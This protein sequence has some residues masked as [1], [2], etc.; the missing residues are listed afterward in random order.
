MGLIRR[1]FGQLYDLFQDFSWL[2][3]GYLLCQP[4]GAGVHGV[5]SGSCCKLKLFFF[6]KV[7]H[8]SDPHVGAFIRL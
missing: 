5:E 7:V 3:S 4:G 8:H 2:W 6:F 1:V